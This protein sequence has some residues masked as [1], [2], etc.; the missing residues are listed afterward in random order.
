MMLMPDCTHPLET[1][2]ATSL[3]LIKPDSNGF[4]QVP[5]ILV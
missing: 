5:G 2:V 4:M 1:Y 3:V